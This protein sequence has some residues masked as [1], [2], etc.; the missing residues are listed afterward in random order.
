[1][2]T[3]DRPTGDS[4]SR[5]ATTAGDLATQLRAAIHVAMDE[6]RPIANP[7]GLVALA[8]IGLDRIREIAVGEIALINGA[9]SKRKGPDDEPAERPAVCGT[10][11]EHMYQP[12]SD[13]TKLC[14]RCQKRKGKAKVP[15][16]TVGAPPATEHTDAKS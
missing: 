7:D 9:A 14:V 2:K 12:Q 10:Y 1:M 15:A 16:A 5:I 4:F 13:G 8:A 3:D 11:R 6:D